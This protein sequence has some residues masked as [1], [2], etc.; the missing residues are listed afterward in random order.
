[1]TSLWE[2]S[3]HSW[4]L[5]RCV[6]ASLAHGCQAACGPLSGHGLKF[7]RLDSCCLGK[8]ARGHLLTARETEALGTN[9]TA[10]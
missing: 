5:A 7:H 8:P 9:Y 4:L 1:M 6:Q 10:M 3:S 2:N